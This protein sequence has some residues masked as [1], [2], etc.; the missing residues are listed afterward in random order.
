MSSRSLGR[1]VPT[2]GAFCRWSPR[3]HGSATLYSLPNYVW[4]DLHTSLG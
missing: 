2:V 3:G 1:T 4:D